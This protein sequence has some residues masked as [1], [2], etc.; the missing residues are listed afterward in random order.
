MEQ[1]NKPP[2]TNRW[3]ST[4]NLKNYEISQVKLFY[5]VFNLY[6]TMKTTKPDKR[7]TGNLKKVI[8][9]FSGP[10]KGRKHKGSIG[11]IME[12]D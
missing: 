1:K 6:Y 10:E 7:M 12:T 8:I 3:L 4:P 2:A 5:P 9:I 11:I